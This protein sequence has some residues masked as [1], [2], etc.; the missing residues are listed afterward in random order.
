[1][2]L[3]YIIKSNFRQSPEVTNNGTKLYLNKAETYITTKNAESRLAPCLQQN[4]V[5]GQWHIKFSLPRSLVAL[6]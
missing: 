1:M 5:R 4:H 3:K 2:A 6:N